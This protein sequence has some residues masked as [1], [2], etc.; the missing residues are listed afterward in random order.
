MK[1]LLKITLATFCGVLY[2]GIMVTCL[3]LM[4]D[5]GIEAPPIHHWWK[6]YV[7]GP[8]VFAE[9]VFYVWSRETWLR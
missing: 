5:E 3:V 8:I 6:F 7:C 4:L 9:V 1:K 2:L